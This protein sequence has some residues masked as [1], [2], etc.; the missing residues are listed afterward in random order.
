MLSMLLDL[1]LVV[2]EQHPVQAVSFCDDCLEQG[3]GVGAGVFFVFWLLFV[4][5]E[6]I[7]M[8]VLIDMDVV[9]LILLYF[10]F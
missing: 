7:M 1:L 10:L 3:G 5:F 2:V 8:F 9:G 4:L 6:C